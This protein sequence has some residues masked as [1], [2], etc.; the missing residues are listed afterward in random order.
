VV[1]HPWADPTSGQTAW[2][3][4]SNPPRVFVTTNAGGL[5]PPAGN[6]W[7]NLA[8]DL[9]NTPNM[10]LTDIAVD[11]TTTWPNFTLYLATSSG[12]FK[13]VNNGAHW[14]RWTT[15]LPA[16]GDQ[17]VQRLRIADFRPSG[18]FKVYAGLWGSGVWW[19]DGSE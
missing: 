12:L 7:T 11:P 13:T 4:V 17:V 8:G 5:S 18:A 15:N 1:T 19:R 10:A 9:P 16:S 6:P 2:L 3:L 14:T